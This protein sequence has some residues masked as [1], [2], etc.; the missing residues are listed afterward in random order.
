MIDRRHEPRT[1]INLGLF[2]WG[3]ETHGEHF[4]QE[5]SAR[6]ISLSGALL[7][8]FEINLQPGDLVGILYLGVEA[9][10]RVARVHCDE[11]GRKLKAAVRRLDSDPCPWQHLLTAP[12]LAQSAG[13]G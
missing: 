12:P 7:S 13:A 5:V 11:Q 2:V 8:G 1:E 9:R 6:D 4:L 3:I 10:F